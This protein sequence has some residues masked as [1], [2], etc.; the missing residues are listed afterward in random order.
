MTFKQAVHGPRMLM[1]PGAASRDAYG[2]ETP[3]R[4]LSPPPA[5]RA[6]ITR[7]SDF[8]A[9]LR[10]ALAALPLLQRAEPD[11]ERGG[12]LLLRHARALAH[13][14]GCRPRS[15]I[16]LAD[17]AGKAAGRNMRRG[18]RRGC[19]AAGRTGVFFIVASSLVPAS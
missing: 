2:A 15:I 14:R 19:P 11:A 7:S 4:A 6:C 13:A 3:H 8:A 5:D 9:P 17:A 16:D 10:A 12:E 1:L 18:P